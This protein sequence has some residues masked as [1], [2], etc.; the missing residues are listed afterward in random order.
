MFSS[1]KYEFLLYYNRAFLLEDI[2]AELIALTESG[3]YI[4]KHGDPSRLIGEGTEEW[5]AW[6]SPY[7]PFNTW[8][9][10]ICHGETGHLT[11]GND[12]RCIWDG[13]DTNTQAVSEGPWDEIV[14]QEPR[15]HG[16]VT[17]HVFELIS[18]DSVVLASVF[19][20]AFAR[21]VLQSVESTTAFA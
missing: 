17:Q 19:G 21:I 14:L 9:V 1:N 10:G 8:F 11:S 18:N 5:V 13:G 4:E 20:F 12:I 7:T 3:L 15:E 2:E 16:V 6:H